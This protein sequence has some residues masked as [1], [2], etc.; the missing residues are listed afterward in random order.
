MADFARLPTKPEHLLRHWQVTFLTG[1]CFDVGL[2]KLIS[3]DQGWLK[4]SDGDGL[5]TMFS[6]SAVLSA[7]Q[8]DI[9]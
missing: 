3:A 8:K 1:A 5:L 4:F 7:K 9:S 2:V 6:T